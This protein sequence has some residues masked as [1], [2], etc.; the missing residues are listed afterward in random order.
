MS[1]RV[2]DFPIEN[3]NVCLLWLTQYKQTHTLCLL[4]ILLFMFYSVR[5][6]IHPS[7]PWFYLGDSIFY[8]NIND[9]GTKKY[10]FDNKTNWEIIDKLESKKFKTRKEAEDMIFDIQETIWK[11]H[12][13]DHCWKMDMCLIKYNISTTKE[14]ILKSL[15]SNH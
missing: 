15:N 11:E 1:S 4:L 6:Y 8:G 9:G 2:I 5:C 12:W 7:R 3:S 13:I 10:Y 14:D